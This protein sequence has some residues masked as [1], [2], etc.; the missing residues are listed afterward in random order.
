MFVVMEDLTVKTWG[1]DRAAYASSP[2]PKDVKLPGPL[3][4][5]ACGSRHHLALT[6]D[7]KVYV[8]GFNDYYQLGL[9]T[10]CKEPQL[11]DIPAGSDKIVSVHAHGNASYALTMAGELWVWGI[12]NKGQLGIGEAVEVRAP[13]K[14]P[15]FPSPIVDLATGYAHVIALTQDGSVWTWGSN[16]N[17]R[18]GVQGTVGEFSSVPL[19]ISVPDAVARVY[20][21]AGTSLVLT[22]KGA[23]YIWGWSD[24]QQLGPESSLVL[25]KKG[26]HY[27]WGWGDRQQ[28]GPESS[29]ASFEPHLL[30]PSGVREVACGYAHYLV[31]LEDGSIWGWG[32][33]RGT[34]KE[35][36]TLPETAG[37]VCG[38]VA[39]YAHA[40]FVSEHGEVY[41][42]GTLPCTL[43]K[44]TTGLRKIMNL[45][46]HVPVSW[47]ALWSEIFAWWFLGR[48]EEN[49]EFHSLPLEVIYH[50]VMLYSY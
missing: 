1:N 13:R 43:Q 26:A 33:W 5:F 36:T 10:P 46:V 40:G 45:K 35:I 21:G 28:L 8:W 37:K 30:F 38:L 16:E 32:D 6:R 2:E 48:M 15:T 25:T 44:G 31:L 23:L 42:L 39:G 22:K 14:G 29:L 4:S 18:L 27:I 7:H 19:K 34:K 3:L 9:Q 17:G 47:A 12:N 41:I 11:L 49:S 20:A 50:L 24:H